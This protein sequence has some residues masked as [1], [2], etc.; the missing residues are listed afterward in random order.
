SFVQRV[1]S[2]S[3]IPFADERTAETHAGRAAR[4]LSFSDGVRA[5]RESASPFASSAASP[6]AASPSSSAAPSSLRTSNKQRRTG[7]GFFPP[8][9][10]QTAAP[11]NRDDDAT[12]QEIQHLREQLARER[13]EKQQLAEQNAA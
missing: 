13:Q 5:Y 1:S 4:D 12:L 6:S 3:R 9:T 8:S 11:F 10:K 2:E 7:A